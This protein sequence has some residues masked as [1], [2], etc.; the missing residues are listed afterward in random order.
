M[1]LS[2][3]LGDRKTI[4]EAEL[5]ETFKP[6]VM[7][8]WKR[9]RLSTR[10]LWGTSRYQLSVSTAHTPLPS[11]TQKAV[12]APWRAADSSTSDARQKDGSELI[13]TFRTATG[14]LDRALALRLLT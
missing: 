5:D 6:G 12:A 8:G 4:T 7:E 3:V 11:C 9:F 2:S 14:F 10:T 13:Q 1:D